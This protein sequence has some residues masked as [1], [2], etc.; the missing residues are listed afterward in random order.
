MNQNI[1]C[2]QCGAPNTPGANF[3]VRC[4]ARLSQPSAGG[5]PAQSAPPQAGTSQ[6]GYAPPPQQQGVPQAQQGMPPQQQSAPQPQQ[7]YAPQ[8]QQPAP[9]AAG[10]EK[11]PMLLLDITGSMNY[12]SGENDRTPRRDLVREAIGIIVTQL[13]QE[14]SQAAHEEGGGGLRTVTFAGGQAR[15]I[16]DLNPGN[17][18]QKWSQISWAGGTRI[19]PGWN[20]LLQTYQEEFGQEPEA[21][22]PT[23]MALV[24]TD[25]E[26][27][28]T[29]QFAQALSQTGGSVYVV[30]A[31]VGYGPDHDAA[32]RAYQAIEQSSAHMRVLTFASETDPQVIARTL[33]RMIE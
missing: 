32:L 1:F 8:A 22:R 30:L 20:T 4:G 5:Q 24:I 26:A 2:T 3:C 17:L 16:G 18:N 10:M 12:A 9:M 33:L 31:I 27:D 28:D 19:M 14:D 23:L 15:D 11:E 21:S 6:Q 25:G 7:S 13:A 29:A